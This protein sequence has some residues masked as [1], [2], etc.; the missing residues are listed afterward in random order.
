[1]AEIINLR[2]KRKASQRADKQRQAEQKRALHGRSK[3]D[4][5]RQAKLTSLQDARHA[6]HRRNCDGPADGDAD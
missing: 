1:M 2:R 4:K 5:Q 3:S 6:G